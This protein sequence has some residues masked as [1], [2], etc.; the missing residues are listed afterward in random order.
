MQ[1]ISNLKQHREE[2]GYSQRELAE[3]VGISRNSI[4]SI[5]RGEYIPSLYHAYKISEILSVSIQ[6]LF[7]FEV[8][9]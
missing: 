6:E 5:E 1:F 9:E 4:S 3:L 8:K 2:R 7:R